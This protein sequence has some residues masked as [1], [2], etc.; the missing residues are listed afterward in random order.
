MNL[1]NVQQ[2]S[3]YGYLEQFT[4]AMSQVVELQLSSQQIEEFI[5]F[6][7]GSTVIA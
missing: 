1:T 2:I 3:P 5:R 4:Y 7:E 6:A